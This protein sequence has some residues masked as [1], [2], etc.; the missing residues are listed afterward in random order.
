MRKILK[1]MFLFI[2]IINISGCGNKQ[3]IN[4]EKQ[5]NK[6]SNANKEKFDGSE[7]QKIDIKGIDKATNINIIGEYIYFINNNKDSKLYKVKLD[8]K[9]LTKLSDDNGAVA[10]A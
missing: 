7:R 6:Q 4:S 10:L 9:D 1:I 2:F 5:L 8:G 3:D